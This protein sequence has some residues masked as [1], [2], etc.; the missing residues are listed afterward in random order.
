MRLWPIF[1]HA[2]VDYSRFFLTRLALVLLAFRTAGW[3]FMFRLHESFNLL[4]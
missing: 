2:F 3:A 4:K 1:T